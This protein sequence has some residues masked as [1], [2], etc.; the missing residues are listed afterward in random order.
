MHH[1][2]A[3]VNYVEE[4][5]QH[6]DYDGSSPPTALTAVRGIQSNINSIYGG[7]RNDIEIAPSAG[8]IATIMNL[9]PPM[10]PASLFVP[11]SEKSWPART[12]DLT[13][14]AFGDTPEWEGA[15]EWEDIEVHAETRRRKMMLPMSLRGETVLAI[16]DSGSEDNIISNDLV[17]TLGLKIEKKP[18]Y[19]KE[20]VLANNSLVRALGRVVV[21]CGFAEEKGSQF[22]CWFYVFKT[23]ISPLIMGM[24]FLDATKTLTENRHRLRPCVPSINRPLQCASIGAKKR[25]LACKGQVLLEHVRHHDWR[26]DAFMANPD[27]GSEEDLV[28]MPDD[29]ALM[30]NVDNS[31][32]TDLHPPQG[33]QGNVIED[34]AF[35]DDPDFG[36]EEDPVN[37]PDDS[38]LMANV[39]ISW[40]AALH[41]PHGEQGNVLEDFVF[42]ANPDSGS[43]VD[44]VSPEF[45]RQNNLP[46]SRLDSVSKVQ[47]ADGS[48]ATLLG[49]TEVR[50]IMGEQQT[51]IFERTFYVLED[52]TCDVLFGE[53]F[54]DVLDPFNTYNHALLVEVGGFPSEVSTIVWMNNFEEKL[55]KSM[56][57]CG[58]KLSKLLERM[59]PF[60]SGVPSTFDNI[61]QSGMRN[62]SCNT[63]EECD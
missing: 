53:D 55:S 5:Q 42:M 60:S 20:F 28:N 41:L 43:E 39:D 46:I 4:E 8:I 16:L 11:G 32:N 44:L 10:H 6:G 19:K 24:E 30:A 25:R 36:S 51:D 13:M 57:K 2:G 17:M 7:R 58:D 35:M 21:T 62:S 3:N 38:A 12:N 18:K 61:A 1:I 63:N 40:N 27:F 31:W 15:V 14:H 50:V 37:M 45:C 34:F 52:L 54:L 26:R 9:I 49:K 33:E 22:K 47:F 48:I 56:N 29:S 59:L 23:L